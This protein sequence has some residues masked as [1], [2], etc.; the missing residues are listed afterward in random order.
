MRWGR[1]GAALT[2]AMVAAT[3]GVASLQRGRESRVLVEAERRIMA[4]DSAA[5]PGLVRSVCADPERRPHAI[6]KL[7]GSSR[8]VVAQAASQELEAA[9]LDCETRREDDAAIRIAEALAREARSYGPASRATARAAALRLLTLARSDDDAMLADCETILRNTEPAASVASDVATLDN[10]IAE[11]AAPHG[12]VASPWPELMHLPG[13]G[14]P[15]FDAEVPGLP[16]SAAESTEIQPLPSAAA[17]HAPVAAPETTPPPTAPNRL[18]RMDDERALPR[19]G[20]VEMRLVDPRAPEEPAEREETA[21]TVVPPQES[22]LPTEVRPIAAEAPLAAPPR[23]LAD[24]DEAELLAA[25]RDSPPADASR[26]EAE[27]RDRGFE[28]NH[29]ELARRLTSR[30]A[31]QRLEWTGRLPNVPGIETTAWLNWLCSDPDPRVRWSAVTLMATA[32]SAQA[33][34]ILAAMS[35]GDRD[36]GLRKK[37]SQQLDVLRASRNR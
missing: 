12:G 37:A 16:R 9:L 24:L 11:S 10:P 34:P 6:A 28:A 1:I 31:E 18:P 4:A 26:I 33:E 35:R 36:L 19:Q 30:D 23:N 17:A 21:P 2:I 25:L 32:D 14:L 7:L 29:L 5:A 15:S 27:L 3:I 22:S 8:E 13:G 20:A